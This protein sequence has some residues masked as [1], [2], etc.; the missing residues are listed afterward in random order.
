MVIM[1]DPA[2]DDL[3]DAFDYFESVRR[4][5][6]HDFVAEFRRAIDH[7]ID[8]P[9][10]W[11]QLDDEFRR[12]RL[13]RF[14]YGVIYRIDEATSRILVASIEQLNRRPDDW[15]KRVR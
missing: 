2:H 1:Q 7:I 4:G 9:K 11:H 3:E 5:L 12:Y 10:A 15:R 6:G 8:H 14:P 13:H